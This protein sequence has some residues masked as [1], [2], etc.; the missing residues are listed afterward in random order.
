MMINLSFAY[1][2]KNRARR[3]KGELAGQRGEIVENWIKF[4]YHIALGSIDIF[5]EN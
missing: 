5:V 1:K 2:D 4:T 3:T